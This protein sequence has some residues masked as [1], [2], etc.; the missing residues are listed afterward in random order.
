MSSERKTMAV[1]ASICTGTTLRGAQCTKMTK[2]PSGYCNIHDKAQK[3]EEDKKIEKKRDNS[4][5]IKIN[6]ELKIMLDMLRK[7][8]VKL[9]ATNVKLKWELMEN[10]NKYGLLLSAQNNNMLISSI[11]GHTSEYKTF[12]NALNVQINSLDQLYETKQQEQLTTTIKL[13]A[14][15]KILSKTGTKKLD[16][17]TIT[18]G[19]Y[20]A[21]YD[22]KF[23]CCI[24]LEDSPKGVLLMC[25]HKM[26]GACIGNM[27]LM[28]MDNCTACPTCRKPMV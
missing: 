21:S 20:T 22:E 5:L 23:E 28:G 18:I 12:M 17:R 8:Q 9:R 24:C 27:I 26:H 13:A 16:N 14:L 1:R 10:D 4:L 6:S 25:G 7:E 15:K 3:K 11:M 19:K 2:N